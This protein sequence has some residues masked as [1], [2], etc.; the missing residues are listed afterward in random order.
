MEQLPGTAGLTPIHNCLTTDWILG[1]FGRNKKSAQKTYRTFIADGKEQPSPWPEL[2]NQIYLGSVQFVEA[3]QGKIQPG[4]SLDDIPKRQKHLPPKPLDYYS[5]KYSS[6]D[7]A[8]AEAYRS[9]QYTLA[10]VGKHFG[11]SYA[12]VSRAV[13]KQGV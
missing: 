9:G 2:K 10:A 7:K 6:R 12:I 1:S 5:G 8:L 3:M 13:K 11:V 4:Q